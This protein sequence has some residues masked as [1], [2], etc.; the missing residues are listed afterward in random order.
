MMFYLGAIAL[1]LVSCLFV[2]VPL[3]YGR[4]AQDEAGRTDLNVALYQEHVSELSEEEEAEQLTLEAQKVL[5]SETEEETNDRAQ[6]ST[7]RHVLILSAVFLPI[8]AGLVYLDVGFGQGSM[9]DVNLTERL[10]TINPADRTA[11]R[12]FLSDVEARVERHPDDEDMQ[13]LLARAYLTL[14]E[15]AASAE[16]M[17]HLVNRF[18]DDANLRSQYA[19]VLY[20]KS[21]RKVTETV[22]QAIDEALRVNPNDITMMELRAIAAI[23]SGDRETAISWFERALGTGVTGRRAEIIRIAMSRLNDPIPEMGTEAPASQGRSLQVQ[24]SNANGLKLA[25]SAVVFVYARAASGPP[26]PLA[27][28][29]FPVTQLPLEL[30]LDESMAMVPGMS[31]GSFDEVVVIARISQSGQ[32]TPS[33][34]DYEAR[35][36]IV[37]LTGSIEPISLTIT[38]PI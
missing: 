17:L 10:E 21:G 36:A 19:E 23:E 22:A 32:V 13:F 6:A 16:V 30:T 25:E 9:P 29:R 12:R 35:S 28:Q 27:V 15:Y 33:P 7:N 5:L 31:L 11:Y 4:N 14:E 37:D 2:L 1:G 18:P 24:V 38:D 8:F 20:L 34:G 26:A 3:L